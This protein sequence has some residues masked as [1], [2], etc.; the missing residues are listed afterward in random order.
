MS[1]VNE[2]R[3]WYPEHYGWD[4]KYH[5][6]QCEEKPMDSAK[7]ILFK[8]MANILHRKGFDDVFATCN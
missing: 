4:G 3:D 6:A 1:L 5:D 7:C 2:Y 8:V